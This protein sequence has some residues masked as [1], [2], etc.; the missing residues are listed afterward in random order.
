M[1]TTNTIPH[2]INIAANNTTT[3]LLAALKII[4]E[5]PTYKHWNAQLWFGNSESHYQIVMEAK[6]PRCFINRCQNMGIKKT[7][8]GVRLTKTLLKYVWESFHN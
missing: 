8:D 5:H 4:N 1:E 7:P 3:A 6:S 2:Q